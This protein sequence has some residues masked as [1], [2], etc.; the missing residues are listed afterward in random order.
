MLLDMTESE[1]ITKGYNRMKTSRHD[2]HCFNPK[3]VF[4]TLNFAAMRH[5]GEAYALAGGKRFQA[6]DAFD[7]N[8]LKGWAATEPAYPAVVHRDFGKVVRANRLRMA[9]GPEVLACPVLYTHNVNEKGEG[10]GYSTKVENLAVMLDWLVAQGYQTVFFSDLLRFI[11]TNRLPPG[12]TKPIV[13]MFCTGQRGVYEHAFKLLKD[14]QL[15][16]VATCWELK[17]AD[18][19]FLTPPQIRE[20]LESGLFEPG[21]Y[22]KWD[23]HSFGADKGP[24]GATTTVAFPKYN[25]ERNE[26]ESLA[27]YEERIF[28]QAEDLIDSLRHDFG[29][30]G[31]VVWEAPATFYSLAMLR[32]ARRLGIPML[33]NAGTKSL[34]IYGAQTMPNLSIV[35]MEDVPG[36]TMEA[37]QQGLIAVSGKPVVREY[38]YEVYVS[39]AENPNMADGWEKNSD[40]HKVVFERPGAGVTMDPLYPRDAE[41]SSFRGVV[42]GRN[43]SY[44]KFRHL[45]LKILGEK[46]NRPAALN[47]I[48]IYCETATEVELQEMR[49]RNLEN[50]G[51]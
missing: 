38:R 49:L 27:V 45:R 34:N 42:D 40:W 15:K 26:F 47:E 24:V 39:A 35:P 7:G 9:L 30:K 3:S 29:F 13:I 18:E 36:V 28:K 31:E 51:E 37:N 19:E 20:M 22:T 8:W 2:S 41:R 1:Q 48:D 44:L 4:R 11:R 6:H 25:A 17:G 21:I 50:E 23:T 43:A 33:I 16:F 32:V 12:I 46:E 5:G 10:R 14:R